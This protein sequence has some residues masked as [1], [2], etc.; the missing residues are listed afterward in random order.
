M[1][2]QTMTVRLP[3]WLDE[4]LREEFTREGEGPSED[5]VA[6]GDRHG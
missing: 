3:E 4:Q 5:R 2:A 1:G 6:R